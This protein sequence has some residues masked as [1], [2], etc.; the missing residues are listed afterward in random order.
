MLQK[1]PDS[2]NAGNIPAV[3]IVGR[4]SVEKFTAF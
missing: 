2:E 3:K 1:T 4:A